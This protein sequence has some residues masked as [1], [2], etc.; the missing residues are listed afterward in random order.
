MVGDSKKGSDSLLVAALFMYYQ[1][2]NVRTRL[3][4]HDKNTLPKQ[5][6]A[7]HIRTYKTKRNKTMKYL[8][9]CFLMKVKTN[10][11]YANTPTSVF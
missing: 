10:K 3:Q 1:N 2:I 11:F 8:D 5:K 9:V 6:N 4:S 7:V